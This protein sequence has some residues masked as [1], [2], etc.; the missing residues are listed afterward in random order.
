MQEASSGFAKTWNGPIPGH[1]GK[2]RRSSEI[3]CCNQSASSINARFGWNTKVTA[4]ALVK[5]SEE[6]WK[7]GPYEENTLW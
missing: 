1:P 4:K 5:A 6:G 2:G 3:E 7:G